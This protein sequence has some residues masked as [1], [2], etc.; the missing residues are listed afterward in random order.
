MSDQ[1]IHC[2]VAQS[3]RSKQFYLT[4]VYGYNQA[5]ARQPLWDA[6]ADISIGMDEAWCVL[7][8][9]NSILYPEDRMGGTEVQD[10]E[11]KPFASCLSICDL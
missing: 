6:L 9:F 10:F 8:D 7:G 2:K 4:F 3:H 1:C 11:I 5:E